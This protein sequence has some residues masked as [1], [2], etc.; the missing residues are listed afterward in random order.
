MTKSA[1]T[2]DRV[3]R[4][5]TLWLEGRTADQIAR[6]LQNGIS[7]SA[8][9]GKVHR[10]GLSAGR[11]GRPPAA[12]GPVA[13]RARVERPVAKP[14]ERATAGGASVPAERAP[15]LLTGGLTI[16]TV[17][18]G[19]CRWPYGDPADAGF[20]LCG[21]PV[22]RGAFCVAH[23]EVGYRTPPGGALSLLSL[24]GLA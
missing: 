11:P 9:L 3:G 7:R 20:S 16:L 14:V 22:A 5:K 23:A 15:D 18:R 4:L 17:R 1:W 19:Q 8:V 10:L 24:A 12:S 13:P 21:R 2:D 6:E